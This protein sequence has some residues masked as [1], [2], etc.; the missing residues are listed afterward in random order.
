TLERAAAQLPEPAP[1]GPALS[2]PGTLLD[3][4]SAR[5]T[6]GNLF[7]ADADVEHMRSTS[8]V[9]DVFGLVDGAPRRGDFVEWAWEPRGER[10]SGARVELW[11]QQRYGEKA[12]VKNHLAYSVLVGDRVLFTQDVTDWQP[13]NTV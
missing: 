1:T 13:R 3:L 4:E 8:K 7:D 2:E 5:V 11:I 6:S 10:A 12:S 9:G